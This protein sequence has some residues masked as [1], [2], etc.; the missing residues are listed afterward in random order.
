MKNFVVYPALAAMVTALALVPSQTRAATYLDSSGEGSL[1]TSN[2]HLD[3]LSVEVN[4]TA[5]DLIFKF[6]LAGNP[7]ATDWGKYMV[8]ISRKINQDHHGDC[9]AA[10]RIKRN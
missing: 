4:N 3:I 8:A 1:L 9:K 2:P 5:T 10:H 6:N 7:V